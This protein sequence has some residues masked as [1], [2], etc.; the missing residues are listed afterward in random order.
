MIMKAPL[1]S[2]RFFLSL[3]AVASF[4]E[5]VIVLVQ[6]SQMHQDNLTEFVGM[7]PWKIENSGS[8]T[9]Q[10]ARLMTERR[11]QELPLVETTK[12]TK[13]YYKPRILVG[14]LADSQTDESK[15]MRNRF[16]RV[17]QLWND[18]RICSLNEFVS[19]DWVD[20]SSYMEYDDRDTSYDCQIV[21]SF[22]L[23]AYSRNTSLPYFSNELRNVSTLKLHETPEEPLVLKEVP[24]PKIFVHS[25][26]IPPPYSDVLE[27]KDGIF[28][29]IVENMNEGKTETY[30]YW[31]SKVS[32]QFNIPFVAKCDTDTVI[33][34][35]K[36]LQFLHQELPK[37]PVRVN[38]AEAR[39]QSIVAGAMRHKPWK[40]GFLP[41]VDESFWQQHYFQGMHLY[42]NGGFYLMSQHL[43][44]L[45]VREARQ[46]EHIIPN[47]KIDLPRGVYN[48]PHAYLE[49]AED[50]DAIAL[51]EQGLFKSPEHKESLMQWLVMPKNLRF[52]SHPV[53][54]IKKW[55]HFLT[56]EQK[57][58][59]NYPNRVVV[60]GPANSLEKDDIKTMLV[61]FN[62]TT[63]LLREKYRSELQN[64][65]HEACN[66]LDLDQ[67]MNAISCDI[68]YFFVVGDT[69]AG[70]Q[71]PKTSLQKQ[72]PTK[73]SKVD[74]KDVLFLK[75]ENDNHLGLG[76][77][78]LN[79]IQAHVK[80]GQDIYKFALTIFCQSNTIVNIKSWHKTVV[81]QLWSS[82]KT[83]RNYFL[84]G[85]VRDK[86]K[87]RKEREYQEFCDYDFFRSHHDA[88]QLYLGSDCFAFSSNL[89][90]L[91]LREAQNSNND[92]CRVG[93]MGHDLAYLAYKASD[94]ILHWMP[95][96]QSM[97]FW[98]EVEMA[99]LEWEPDLLS[100]NSGIANFTGVFPITPVLPS[101]ALQEKIASET[102]VQG[103]IFYK[104][105]VLVGIV[106]DSIS[107]DSQTLRNRHR[108]LFSL[109]NDP[110]LCSLNEFRSRS[111]EQKTFFE[112]GLET[113]LDYDCQIVYSFVLAAHQQNG[114]SS[115]FQ[116][117]ATTLKLYD[118]PEQPLVLKPLTHSLSTN[119][120]NIPFGDVLDHED[121]TFLNIVENMNRGKTATFLFWASEMSKQW[122]IPYVAKCDSDSF[123]NLT[124][125]LNFIHQ[126]LPMVPKTGNKYG[127]LKQPSVFAGSP[128]LRK[129]RDPNWWLTSTDD[130]FWEKEYFLGSHLYY[131]GG[132]YLMSRD[133]AESSTSESRRL[134]HHVRRIVNHETRRKNK[135]N[136][137][138]DQPH[139]YL[140]GTEDAD[141]FGTAE[142]GHYRLK[143]D[144]PDDA[145]T[146]IQ[147]MNIPHESVFHLH[148][149]K[150]KN[151]LKWKAL[152][153]REKR[154]L[155][156]KSQTIPSNPAVADSVKSDNHNVGPSTVKTLIVIY[157]ANTHSDREKYRDGLY[158]QGKRVCKGLRPLS[159][160]ISRSEC[161]IHYIFAVGRSDGGIDIPKENINDV[162]TLVW[163][164]STTTKE[165]EEIDDVLFLNVQGTNLEGVGLSTLFYI[166]QKLQGRTRED[167]YDLIVFAE[168]SHMVNVQK[169]QNNIVST[170]QYSVKNG[171][172]INL[173]IGDV[174][175]KG[176]NRREFISS[177]CQ[178]PLGAFKYHKHHSPHQMQLYLGSDC[179][180]LSSS[181]V[182]LWL[183]QAKNPH[184]GR[185]TEGHLGH[186]LTYLSHFAGTKLHWMRV[187]KSL[188]FWSKLDGLD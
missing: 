74:E 70:V 35:Q 77:A 53:K 136:L 155:K 62:A 73:F 93:Q 171:R 10:S 129:Q 151:K 178:N 78:A 113:D 98:Y 184:V 156:D 9:M 75:V 57:R 132:F 81:S 150:V 32:R 89:V 27:H 7:Q 134:E 101:M 1:V 111:W 38:D 26:V 153:A 140:E 146:V 12:T 142:H 69:S 144:N 45:A 182:S 149:V 147:W 119:T 17:F 159:D 92:E 49:G 66:A 50:H 186:D 185:C 61:I 42:L 31:A 29:N 39:P 139:E 100:A 16:R 117:N 4:F 110:R 91:L 11:T 25:D 23:S 123:L 112:S 183:E 158:E 135:M 56:T 109:W 157:G 154:Y 152:W 160:S 128:M 168:A 174:R 37:S 44:E 173:L 65:G 148:P 179:F 108:Q 177:I 94:V 181:V 115:S 54:N 163:S 95:V 14:I 67:G 72:D 83:Q 58:I 187:P 99:P 180:A 76:L 28:L 161:D 166:D 85:D 104:P 141:A 48:D 8:E 20:S 165:A 46:L 63:T 43:A 52:F 68:F 102:E 19:K 82:L 145:P 133:L 125:F 79:Y 126:D 87:N 116:N 24:T 105:R 131:N 18:S 6:T 22:V 36:L 88:I 90:P 188:Q 137:W 84:I 143:M 124:A 21:Y 51:A 2:W 86:M 34:F 164:D 169:W 122:N 55:E 176:K 33:R 162:S 59:N 97:Q 167:R 47:I 121:G 96:P 13:Q 15:E 30:L 175:D 3:A 107:F 114:E 120:D 60:T 127:S 170:A 71:G 5:L 41:T 172:Q 118:T 106:S 80:S 138:E 40:S 103:Q 64:Q 130:A